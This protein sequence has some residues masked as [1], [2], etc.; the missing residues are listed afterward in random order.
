MP[1]LPP[2]AR[3]A[4]PAGPPPVPK[5]PRPDD[6]T[7]VRPKAPRPP[8]RKPATE[9]PSSPSIDARAELAAAL[10]SLEAKV[11][12]PLAEEESSEA[13]AREAH[14]LVEAAKSGDPRAFEA[15]V[16]RYRHRIFALALHMTGSPSDAD[17][18]T[19]DAFVR[20]YR[21]ID[22]F[23]GRSEFFTWLYR[24]A[25]NRALNVR[26]DRNRRRTADLDDPR[27]TVAVAVDSGG[28]PHRALELR[29]TYVY[30]VRA[31][32]RLSPLLKTTVALTMMQG[33]SYPEAA[34]VL[35][36]TEGTIA[37]RIHEA[38]KQMRNALD[39]MFKD[40]SALRPAEL[41]R[42]RKAAA[43]ARAKGEAEAQ[44]PPAL[45]MALALLAPSV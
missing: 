2:S 38:R 24:I 17:D 16:K 18:I 37:W 40:P 8:A 33:L 41:E 7:L 44:P 27:V 15:L 6:T 13:R 9:P 10:D 3:I 32:D 12:A 36:T 29:Q 34:V 23:E 31:F 22:R 35:E 28:D 43:E 42:A 26:R 21:N 39:A 30:L 25:L 5:S 11:A 45:E 19:Q 14:E 20:A 4:R 1:P